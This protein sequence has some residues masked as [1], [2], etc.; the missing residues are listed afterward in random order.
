MVLEAGYENIMVSYTTSDRHRVEGL[1][2][3]ENARAWN[4][5]PFEVVVRLCSMRTVLWE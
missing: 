1:R 2:L 3:A 4:T 5:D